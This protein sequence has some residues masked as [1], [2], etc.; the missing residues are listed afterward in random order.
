MSNTM[1]HLSIY[2]QYYGTTFHI[3]PILWDIWYVSLRRRRRRRSRD[4][5][6]IFNDTRTC[7][8]EIQKKNIKKIKKKHARR[9]T[10]ATNWSRTWY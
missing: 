9:R 3:C 10:C 4:L 5:L 2:V 7:A 8:N 6:F 1:G